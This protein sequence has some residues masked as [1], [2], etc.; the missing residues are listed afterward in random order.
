MAGIAC[1]RSW[2]VGIYVHIYI[3][4]YIINTYIHTHTHTS[5]HTYTH[6]DIYIYICMEKFETC[7]RKHPQSINSNPTTKYGDRPLCP[8]SS[9]EDPDRMAAA[10]LTSV[11]NAH[12]INMPKV[13]CVSG[14]QYEVLVG[15]WNWPRTSLRI[16]E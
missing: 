14:I 9:T 6:H 12:H 5:V 16:A 4:I 10:S 15:I 1:R 2:M 8:C 13:C 3:Y 11:D 7:M